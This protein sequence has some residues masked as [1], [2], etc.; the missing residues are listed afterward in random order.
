MMLSIKHLRGGDYITPNLCLNSETWET[1]CEPERDAILNAF[2]LYLELG[3]LI[4]EEFLGV[5]NGYSLRFNINCNVD[6]YNFYLKYIDI[7]EDFWIEIP[8]EI[9]SKYK[10][11]VNNEELVG[12]GYYKNGYFEFILNEGANWDWDITDRLIKPYGYY[13]DT[14]S[15]GSSFILYEDNRLE[16]MV[17]GAYKL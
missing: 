1:K 10:V 4:S 6:L 16:F 13:M 12:G 15:M 2:P 9:K 7:N 3:E 5:F 17:D 8:D 11:Y 14:T